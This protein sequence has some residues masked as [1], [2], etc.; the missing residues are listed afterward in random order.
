MRCWRTR[1]AIRTACGSP[2]GMDPPV[3]LSACTPK[4][5]VVLEFLTGAAVQEEEIRKK[6]ATKKRK[7]DRKFIVMLEKDRSRRWL[8]LVTD[9]IFS[10]I[11]VSGCRGREI[12]SAG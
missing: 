12:E 3:R 11:D 8:V 7:Q 6:S 2:A 9:C 10:K 4:L 5:R 1:R